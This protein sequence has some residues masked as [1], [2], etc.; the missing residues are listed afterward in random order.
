MNPTVEYIRAAAECVRA[1]AE[2]E[3][4]PPAEIEHEVSMYETWARMAE[5][6]V[7]SADS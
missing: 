5:R 3:K 7:N 4:Q 2:A 1:V 6:A